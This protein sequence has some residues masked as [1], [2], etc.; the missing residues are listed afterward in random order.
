M[1]QGIR[2]EDRKFTEGF[3]PCAEIFYATR[4]TVRTNPVL[5]FYFL[6]FLLF[7]FA[8]GCGS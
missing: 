8:F 5:N 6:F 4:V 7:F 1:L 2:S 3:A